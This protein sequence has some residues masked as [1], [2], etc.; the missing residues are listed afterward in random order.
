L[1]LSL[2]LGFVGAWFCV[3]E[4]FFALAALV[5]GLSFGLLAHVLGGFFVGLAVFLFGGL[6]VFFLDNRRAIARAW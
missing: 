1:P 3:V 2:F 5:V 6:V 4:N